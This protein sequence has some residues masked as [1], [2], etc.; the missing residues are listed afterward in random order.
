VYRASSFGDAMSRN[1]TTEC[2]LLENETKRESS[3]AQR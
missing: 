1:A 3:D 2:L